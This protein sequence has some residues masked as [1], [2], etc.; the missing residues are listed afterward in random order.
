M[1]RI[2][3]FGLYEC[4]ECGQIHIKPEYGSISTYVSPNIFYSPTTMKVCKGCNSESQFQNYRF[5]RLEQKRNTKELSRIE[6][7]IRKLFNRPYIEHDVRKLYP[8][9]D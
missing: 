8:M 3:S 2:T 4:K 5:I 9:F 1:T 6:I 7:F